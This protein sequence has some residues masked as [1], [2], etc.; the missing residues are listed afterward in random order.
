MYIYYPVGNG[1]RMWRVSLHPTG[2]YIAALFSSAHLHSSANLSYFMFIRNSVLC[3]IQKELLAF[4]LKEVHKT[5][6]FCFSFFFSLFYLLILVC[7]V[8]QANIWHNRCD[9]TDHHYQQGGRTK[10]C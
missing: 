9:W 4:R 1:R 7:S 2:V 5:C 6:C 8:L 3:F 10:A